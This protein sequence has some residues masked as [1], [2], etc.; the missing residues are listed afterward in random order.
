MQY[1]NL[2]NKEEKPL[3][4]LPCRV[5]SHLHQ[6]KTGL[7]C[8]LHPP[9]WSLYTHFVLL[10]MK[11]QD[12]SWWSIS[13]KPFLIQC[14][15]QAW[16]CLWDPEVISGATN[17][18]QTRILKHRTINKTKAPVTSGREVIFIFGMDGVALLEASKPAESRDEIS[19]S[20]LG[21]PVFSVS[22]EERK[23]WKLHLEGVQTSRRSVMFTCQ[24][25]Q[26]VE[27]YQKCTFCDVSKNNNAWLDEWWVIYPDTLSAMRHE[28][29]GQLH[30]ATNQFINCTFTEMQSLFYS[31]EDF[32]TNRKQVIGDRRDLFQN[33]PCFQK[34]LWILQEVKAV[35]KK[36]CLTEKR[37]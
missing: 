24:W 26:I 9:E 31:S 11:M 6:C 4:L 13:P 12:A 29:K 30:L 16:W 19:A 3:S 14:S 28:V 36:R 17:E 22:P 25:D 21:K 37:P 8:S 34:L 18:W 27:H 35:I 5:Y 1:H 32:T 20:V 7:N 10:W 33:K 2:T 15:D 23:C